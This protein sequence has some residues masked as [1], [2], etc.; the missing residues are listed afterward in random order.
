MKLDVVVEVS[1]FVGLGVAC[2]LAAAA[3]QMV[4]ILRLGRA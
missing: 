1:A 2:G 3:L 4:R